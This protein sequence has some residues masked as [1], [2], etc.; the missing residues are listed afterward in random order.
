M[1]AIVT[2][3]L[4]PAIDLSSTV[5]RVVP[6]H[7]LRCTAPRYEPGGGGIN[8]GRAVHTL[9]GEAA[10]YCAAG[11]ATGHALRDLLD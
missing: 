1:P 6:G 11:G 9:G 7:K 2:L 5:D 8:I 4:N 3:T 10:V